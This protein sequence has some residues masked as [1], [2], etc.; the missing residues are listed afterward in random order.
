M[1]RRDQDKG[2]PDAKAGSTPP[3]QI[4]ID[5]CV[6]L[7]LVK[8]HQQQAVLGALEEMVSQKK[9]SLIL[10]RT[11]LDEFTR[12]KARVIDESRQSLSGTLKRVKEIVNKFGDP[13]KKGLVLAHLNDVDHKLPLLGDAAVVAVAQVEQLFKTAPVTELSD[14]VM[15]RASRR[16]IEGKA[17]FHRQRNSINDAV[18]IETYSGVANGRD[19]QGLRFM[20]VTHNVKDFSAPNTNTKFPHPDIMS[21]FSRV[22]SQ[23]FTRLLDALRR[24]EPELLSDILFEHNWQEEP[25]RLGE[26]LE[27]MDLLFHQVWYNRHLNTRFRIK[28]G[29]IKIVEQETFPVKDHRTRPVQ[30]KTWEAALKA[31]ARVEK[32]YGQENLG[33][34]D[35]FEWGMLNGKLS[36]LRWALGDEWDMLDT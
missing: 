9:I 25:R 6:W 14:E 27:A 2:G 34:W 18:L 21:C 30:R 26:I 7:D 24:V 19:T 28:K 11:V 20:F 4:L 13:K 23:Y 16:A 15:L 1:K 22:K 33:P 3:F 31:A 12:N 36:A 17:P 5:T 35:D 8:D 10:P 29:Q 32:K